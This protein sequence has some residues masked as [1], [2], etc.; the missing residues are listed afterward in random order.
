MV[1][2]KRYFEVE[3]HGKLPNPLEWLKKDRRSQ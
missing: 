1:G 3:H 2:A